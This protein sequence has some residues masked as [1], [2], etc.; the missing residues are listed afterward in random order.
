MMKRSLFL[1][2]MTI[3]L[4][5]FVQAA[6]CHVELVDS[7]KGSFLVSYDSP[8]GAYIKTDKSFTVASGTVLFI[9]IKMKDRNYSLD[10]ISANGERIS[11]FPY[12]TVVEDTRLEAHFVE[13]TMCNVSLKP[14]KN[15]TVTM[16][17]IDTYDMA[18]YAWEEGK[19]IPSNSMLFV[20]ATPDTD[21]AL[22]CVMYNGVKGKNN[23]TVTED[24]EVEVLFKPTRVFFDYRVENNFDSSKGDVVIK[25]AEGTIYNTDDMVMET[26]VLTVT[27][28][29]N[30]GYK[31]ASFKI[32]GDDFT[33]EIL[34]KGFVSFNVTKDV[35]VDT[36]F[37][38][39]SNIEEVEE[40]MNYIYDGSLLYFSDNS[41]K[42]FEVYD[43]SGNTKEVS[44]S[45]L[46]DLSSYPSGVYLVRITS[47]GYNNVIKIIKE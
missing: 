9:E 5:V 39:G 20:K 43:I 31:V 3:L 46:L 17:Y 30:D 27:V 12:F 2:L 10:Y 22:D 28:T 26:T 36:E 35:L 45:E 19:R 38:G 37:T 25:D 33:Q 7:D 21:Y 24:V 32:T 6:D 1:I 47:D 11:D 34:N 13:R 29:P 4:P 15:G 44:R 40:E 41:K 16:E 8:D 18:T 14:V 42:L 23:Y